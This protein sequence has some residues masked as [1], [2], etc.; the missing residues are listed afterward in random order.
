MD[1][2]LNNLNNKLMAGHVDLFA[3]NLIKNQ[4]S[5]IALEYI[6]MI[7]FTFLYKVPLVIKTRVFYI[8]PNE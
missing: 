4:R 3:R 7:N 2:I 8:Q 1:Q 6:D 5:I